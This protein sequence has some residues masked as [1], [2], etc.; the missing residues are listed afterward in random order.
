MVIYTLE[1]Y[2]KMINKANLLIEEEERDT[3]N[4]INN[5]KITIYLTMTQ[6]NKTDTLKPDLKKKYLDKLH[7]PKRKMR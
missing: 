4:S 3:D 7:R 5:Y 1:D 6:N 2:K